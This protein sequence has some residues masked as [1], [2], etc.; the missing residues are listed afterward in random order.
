MRYVHY[1][2]HDVCSTPLLSPF[3]N[4]F[5]I[6]FHPDPHPGPPPAPHFEI[7]FS[8]IELHHT[9]PG[10][11]RHLGRVG[12]RPAPV[13]GLSRVPREAGAGALDLHP[14]GIGATVRA[15]HLSLEF[16]LR[17]LTGENPQS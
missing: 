4:H 8:A 13:G 7:L 12:R 11:R 17:L 6:S 14:H 16:Q 3:K 9:V 10:R 1:N 15:N 2:V 5:S